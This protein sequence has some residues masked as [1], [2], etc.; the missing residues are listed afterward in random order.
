[1]NRIIKK[2][3]DLLNGL[4]VIGLLISYLSPYVDPL[5]FWPVSFFG[6]AFKP[7]FGLNLTLLFLWIWKGKKRWVYNALFILLGLPFA[8]RNIQFFNASS[9]QDTD[10][11][12]ASFNTYVQQIYS[13]GNTTAQIDKYL[14]DN[15][16]DLA[17]LIEWFDGYGDISREEYP[18]Q[19]FIRLRN[20]TK[21]GMRFVSKH[22]IVHWERI[23]YD[24]FTNNIAAYFDIDIDGTIIRF[25]TV[26]LQSNGVSSKDYHQLTDVGQNEE[27]KKHAFEFI[28]KLKTHTQRRSS[29]TKTVLKS[30]EDSP[31]PVVIMGDFNDTPQSYVYQTLRGK[32]KDAF[33]EKGNRWGATYLKPFPL[34]RIDY[35]LHDE[36]LECTSYNCVSE[37]K[38]DHALVEASFRIK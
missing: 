27:Y 30:I 13:D 16:H 37:I 38:S 5:D 6:L 7:L 36:E 19:I 12:V 32:R 1:M 25:V 14:K 33:M 24:H 17:V 23:K 22:K 15:N 35:I 21:Y 31:Y 28:Q 4:A 10:I 8:G 20:A 2:L 11:N 9:K 26:H 18:H 34:L 29:Q 3:L